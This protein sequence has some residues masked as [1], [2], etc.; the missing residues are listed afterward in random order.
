M[1]CNTGGHWVLCQVFPKQGK[2][3]LYDSL[4]GSHDEKYRLKDI[5]CLLYLLPSIL[6]HSGYYEEL[7][8]PP[9]SSA[10]KAV[11]VDNDL[12]PQQDDGYCFL[13]L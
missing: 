10:F 1:P 4:W 3:E 5:R 11:N 12:I 6:K 2:V 7:N 8:M 13:S 9:S